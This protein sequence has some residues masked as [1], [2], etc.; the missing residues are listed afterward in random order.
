MQ[1]GIKEREVHRAEVAARRAAIQ[2]EREAE[3][4]ALRAE[5]EESERASRE[6][7]DD[8]DSEDKSNTDGGK[9]NQEVDEVIDTHD[10]RAA[11]EMPDAAVDYED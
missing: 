7:V 9:P 4:A 1:R 2:A 10:D 3:R 11:D 5:R 8:S 6:K